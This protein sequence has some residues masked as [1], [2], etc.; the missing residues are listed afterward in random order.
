MEFFFIFLLIVIIAVL[1]MSIVI[2]PQ[3]HAYVIEF[4]GK[5]RATWSAGFH[6]KVPVLE[7]IAFHEEYQEWIR[8]RAV[9]KLLTFYENHQ[10]KD[11]LSRWLSKVDYSNIS[12]AYRKRLMDYY[13][14]VGMIENT[15]FGIELYGSTIMG[16]E[17]RL[18]LAEFGVDYY[19]G[20][21]DETTLSL[22]YSAFM[23]KKNTRKTL[24]Y[25]MNH[26]QSCWSSQPMSIHRIS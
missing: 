21:M 1:A 3:E 16:A 20:E 13:M 18:K 6:L 7:R 10:Q 15:F 4:L 11:E 26:F 17:K 5:Y 22:A 9:E 25:L 12:P 24:T 19:Q 2:V 14:E 8:I 23:R